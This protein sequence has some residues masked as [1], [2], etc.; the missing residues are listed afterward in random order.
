MKNGISYPSLR[1]IL[2]IL[3][4]AGLVTCEH[5]ILNPDGA[6]LTKSLLYSYMQEWYLW[7]DTIPEVNPEEYPSLQALLDDIILKPTDRWSYV[8]G[9]EDYNRLFNLGEYIGHGI[10]LANGPEN[11]LWVGFVFE[12]TSAEANGVARGWQILSINGVSPSPEVNLDTLLGYDEIGIENTFQFK[13]ELGGTVNLTLAKEIININTVLYSDILDVAGKKTG[14]LVYQQFLSSDQDGLDEVF[15]EFQENNVEEVI[16]DLRYN[17]GGVVDVARHLASLIAGT[18]AIKGT[19]VKFVY[20]DKKPDRNIS[21]SYHD[22]DNTLTTTPERVFFITTRRTASSSEALING[23]IPYV[24]V[25]LVGD[26]TYGKPVGSRNY[27]LPDSTLIPIMF[28]LYNRWDEGD[29]FDGLPANS[30]IEEDI[31]IDFGNPEEKMLKEVLY[32]I[33]NEEWTGSG[34]KKSERM[35]WPRMEGIRSQT[36]A[37]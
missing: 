31:T 1:F 27:S 14:Y 30:Y 12:G 13:N 32:Y 33:E 21:M 8:M 20:N 36:G 4:T 7:Y 35:Y 11:S 23:M 2:I 10:G 34:I 26:D 3:L 17:P 9:T 15:K 37:I 29:F 18:K 6:K 22:L 25:F 24:D 19:F 16:V 28:K 5:S